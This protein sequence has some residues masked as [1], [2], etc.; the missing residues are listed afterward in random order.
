[1]LLIAAA[2]LVGGGAVALT[3][4]DGRAWLVLTLG[5]VTGWCAA[6]ALVAAPAGPLAVSASPLPEPTRAPRPASP[7]A[8][9]PTVAVESAAAEEPSPAAP[10]P[11]ATIEPATSVAPAP[12]VP[13]PAAAAVVPGQ[14]APD[15][16]PAFAASALAP[17]ALAP[18]P[19][20]PTE[21]SPAQP[22]PGDPVLP[23]AAVW[24]D[25]LAAR[26]RSRTAE[27]RRSIRDVIERLDED[28]PTPP[29]RRRP[30]APRP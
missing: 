25:E 17:A 28:E 4:G 15:P 2:A 18:A 13:L 8:P 24:L 9:S 23:A 11:T 6:S 22:A 7:G 29:R 26:Q 14:A 20:P 30:K 19:A 16:P 10:P 21:P 27:L 1:M 3:V 5:V 12:A